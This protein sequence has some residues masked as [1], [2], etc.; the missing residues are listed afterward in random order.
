MSRIPLRIKTAVL[1]AALSAAG[2]GVA[3]ADDSSLNPFTG[4]SYAAFSGG[5]DR[6]AISNPKLDR[7]ASAWR[8]ANPDG[9]S[10]RVFESYSAP[11]EAWHLNPPIYASAPAVASFRQTHPDGLTEREL[12]ALSSDGSTWQLGA[13]PGMQ[14]IAAEE[15]T[16][17]AQ[18]TSEPLGNRI[19]NFFGRHAS[20]AH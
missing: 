6:P 15:S 17:V 19:A 11:G 5:Y 12:Q 13:A 3:C 7:A 9:L 2:T 16:T 10:E 4:E 1:V 14:S 20:A 18:G 8:Q